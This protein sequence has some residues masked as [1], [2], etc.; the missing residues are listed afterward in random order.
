LAFA[1]SRCLAGNFTAG[2]AST[3]RKEGAPCY[4]YLN[5]GWGRGRECWLR[6]KSPSCAWRFAD[7]NSL[8]KSAQSVQGRW[9]DVPPQNDPPTST[10]PT[11]H[12][13]NCFECR[14]NPERESRLRTGQKSESTKRGTYPPIA[15]AAYVPFLTLQCSPDVWSHMEGI[16]EMLLRDFRLEFY[17]D[18]FA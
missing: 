11:I 1:P 2:G 7:R 15:L 13:S 10:Q 17:G 18:G 12:P 5:C 14:S 3:I 16:T 6:P 4:F 8:I 9:L